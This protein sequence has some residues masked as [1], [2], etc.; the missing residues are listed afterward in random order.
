MKKTILAIFVLWVLAYPG[1]GNAEVKMNITVLNDEITLNRDVIYVPEDYTTIQAA[2]NIAQSG[3][4]IIVS[5]GIYQENINFNGKSIIVGSLFYATGDPYYL[6]QT[7]IDGNQNGNVVRFENGETATALLTGFT[8]TNGYADRG[9]GIYCYAASPT[10]SDLIIENNTAYQWDGGGIY[11]QYNAN[12]HLVNVTIQNNSAEH[13]GGGILCRDSNT[14]PVLENVMIINNTANRE[15]GGISC[16]TG[17][18]LNNVTIAFNSADNAGGGIYCNENSSV[19]F[20]NENRCNIYLNN[21]IMRSSGSDI[22]SE[23]TISVIV[24]TFTVLNPTS[25]HAAPRENFTFDIQQ[26]LL[27]QVNADLYVSPDGN[28]ASSGLSPTEPLQTIQ[29]ACSIITADSLNQRTIHLAEGIY[30][31]SNNGEFFPVSLPDNV[32]LTG[33]NENTVILDAEGLAGVI[34]MDNAENVTISDLTIENGYAEHGSG[35]Y[36]IGSDPI[37]ENLIIRNNTGSYYLSRGGGIYIEYDSAPLL[38]NLVIENNTACFGG[39]IYIGYN[40]NASLHNLII[41]GNSVTSSGGGILL[42]SFVEMNEIVITNNYSDNNGGGIAIDNTSANLDNVRVENNIADYDGG[43]IYMFDS[44]PNMANVSITHN[45]ATQGGGI[46]FHDSSPVFSSVNR[47]SIYDNNAYE[48]GS[49]SDLYSESYI[50]VIVDT[51]TVINPT[52]YHAWHIEDF[53]FDILQGLYDQTFSDIYVSPDGDNNNSGLSATEPFRTIQHA[54]SVILTNEHEPQT[55]YLA[56][57]IYSP[58]TNGECFPLCLPDFVNLQGSGEEQVILEAEG[59]SRLMFFNAHQNNTISD[60]TLSGGRALFGGGI[61]SWRSSPV[62]KNVT[63]RDNSAEL[64]GGGMFLNAESSPQLI[65]VTFYNN[66]S[67]EQGSAISCSCGSNPYLINVTI[68][69]NNCETSGAGIY[70]A[71]SHPVMVNS[72]LWNNDPSEVMFANGSNDEPSSFS[73]GYSTILGGEVSIITQSNGTVNWLEGNIDYDPLF[74]DAGN[75]DYSLQNGSP[76][77]DAGTAYFEFD[78]EI[79][80]NLEDDEYWGTSPDMG[81]YEYYPSGNEDEELPGSNISLSNYPNPFNPRTTIQLN[82]PVST[83]AVLAVYN[84]KGQLV[85]EIYK[86]YLSAGQHTYDWNGANSSGSSLPS[87]IYLINFS[88]QTSHTSKKVLLLK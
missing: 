25:F 37:M 40:I 55:I 8:I 43:G 19:E 86:G 46:R 49:G 13:D 12:P 74:T 53:E 56:E 61:N 84:T 30:S 14:V 22:Y 31:A 11:I 3:D 39:G 69:D 62:F 83:K 6:S 58:S 72:I 70:C 65:N 33:E 76:C 50:S 45:Q 34:R 77:I 80:V 9:G 15:G 2:I 27:E 36:C 16:H 26:G 87:G 44:T 54:C 52:D 17:L 71:N 48:R 60:L 7:I 32:I 75:G 21:T 59:L 28:N 51:F 23:E 1:I 18:N 47:C 85:R 29:Y 41:Q 35:I 64:A 24:D 38:E 82:L 79:L 66:S 63:F 57:G 81:A 67:L 20:N 42:R 88:S 73:L 78:G 4:E 10:L 68:A 5:P